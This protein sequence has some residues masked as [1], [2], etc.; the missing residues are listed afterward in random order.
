VCVRQAALQQ[1]LEDDDGAMKETVDKGRY[2]TRPLSVG[3]AMD[4]NR[5]FGA[6]VELD[7]VGTRMDSEANGGGGA[8]RERF[9]SG[10]FTM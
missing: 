7:T 8:A 9:Q 3:A 6:G 2:G 5:S 4:H 10:D 1:K